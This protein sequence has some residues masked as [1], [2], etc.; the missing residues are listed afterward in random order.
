MNWHLWRANNKWRNYSKEEANRLV[1][2]AVDLYQ[3]GRY[4][5]AIPL[6]RHA[7]EIKRNDLGPYNPAVV[8][9][10]KKLVSHF[11]TPSSYAS[12]KPLYRRAL[13]IWEKLLAPPPAD[14]AILLDCL[15]QILDSTGSYFAAELFLRRALEILEKELGLEHS[16]VATALNNLASVLNRTGN[17]AAAEPL[18][19]RALEIWEKTLGSDHPN[20]AASLGNLAN[21]LYTTGNYA[22]AEPLHRRAL[23]ILEK[24]FGPNHLDVAQS[25]NSLASLL[26]TTG[27]F[28]LAEALHRHALDIREKVLG[29]NHPD[30]AV[31]L[32]NLASLLK[33][34]GNYDA[35]KLLLSR[36]LDIEEKALC[37]DH[38]DLVYSLHNQASLLNAL[39]DYEAAET[40][41]R[42]AL[43]INEKALGPD[44]PLVA[45][46]VHN[47]AISL[48]MMGNYAAAEP[49]YRRAIEIWEKAL[50]PSHP[51][52]GIAL[53]NLACLLHTMGNYAAA[54]SLQRRA[55]SVSEKALGSDHPHVAAS[56]NSLASQIESTGDFASAEPLY[57]RAI[58]IRERAFGPD[59]PD[60][61]ASLNDLSTLLKESGRYSAAESL[62]YR[63]LDI[64]ERVLGPDHPCVADSL[65]NLAGL[66][67]TTGNHVNAE[68]FFLRS[69]A[70]AKKTDSSNYPHLFNYSCFLAATSRPSA[71]IT[72]AKQAVNKCQQLRDNVAMMGKDWLSSFDTTIESAYQHL[73]GL[74]AE[75]DRTAE[76]EQILN[77]LK[78]QEY[79]MAVRSA[80][81][82]FSSS[83]QF[84]GTEEEIITNADS[85]LF[86]ISET[87]RRI[88]D[89]RSCTPRTDAQDKELRELENLARISANEFQ[90]ALAE[91]EERSTAEFRRVGEIEEASALM[92]TL[93][94][95]GDGT[96][97]V[98]TLIDKEK[99]HTF[100]IGPGYRKHISRE[101]PAK[102]FH[103]KVIEF[104][105]VLQPDGNG[106][107][108]DPLPLAQELYN[109]ILR[110]IEK[111]LSHVPTV[112]WNLEGGLR[113]VPMAA[114]HDGNGYLVER[115]RSVSLIPYAI[116]RLK[117]QS[118]SSWTGIGIGVST[119]GKGFD[120]LPAV[121][122]E[123][124]AI[125][126][127]NESAQGIIEGI[128]LLDEQAT[129]DRV[130]DTL[131]SKRFGAIHI[132][133][134]FK[135]NPVQMEASQ[136]LMGGAQSV[137]LKELKIEDNLF[138]GAELLTLSACNTACG[139]PNAT[140]KEVDSLAGCA[141]K[142]GGAK[143]VMASLWEVPDESTAMLMQEFYRLRESGYGK[144]EALQQAQLYLLRRSCPSQN[145]DTASR[146]H[147][148]RHFR[149]QFDEERPYAHPYF[150]A[151]FI[152]MG[153]WR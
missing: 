75:Q 127:D 5:K 78:E 117:E 33:S 26:Y 56:L 71:A 134:H 62:L 25:L 146:S 66:L 113:Y 14:E 143:A 93:R 60:V 97:A 42:R 44:H 38:P 9:S 124:S 126:K 116:D 39:G 43:D 110:P 8:D 52:V 54:E 84:N 10:L 123:I 88:S 120:P 100:L 11:G 19:R 76:S 132:A 130:R 40:L 140:G 131:T 34:V 70:M 6:A 35:A 83:I 50:G 73:S 118:S 94:E 55:L 144:D 29:P 3:Q 63:A 18:H 20:V 68:L 95:I 45:T 107:L 122:D 106:I 4:S 136:L 101:I 80:H 104:R 17:F 111:E 99:F 90:E 125:I 28:S 36:A 135:L 15:A 114:L 16:S 119:G 31:S 141:L 53:N 92:L 81:A 51:N 7:L 46:L 152:L 67:G 149:Y 58:D 129:W 12:A 105:K 148:S 128:R 115:F 24:T 59:H 74:L 49:L 91:I 41:Y 109:I 69:I 103:D 47:L 87:Y 30:V 32:S 22:A 65:N 153:N 23:A 147:V 27:N 142:Q 112:L 121:R 1:L 137:S 21:M 13:G 64:R 102:E 77:L 2:K 85:V 145:M 57:R 108:Y 133:S 37:S 150:W 48:K 89:L 139:V 79:F 61:A 151:P 96:V 98:Y 86:T 72:F 82:D 138:G